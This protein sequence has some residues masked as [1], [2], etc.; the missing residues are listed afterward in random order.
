MN[1][2]I[3]AL[4]FALICTILAAVTYPGKPEPRTTKTTTHAMPAAVY[5]RLAPKEIF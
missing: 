3:L 1:I 5:E 2:G 4:V